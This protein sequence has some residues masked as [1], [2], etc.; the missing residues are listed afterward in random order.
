[1]DKKKN[2]IWF[3]RSIQLMNTFPFSILIGEG[4]P[5]YVLNLIRHGNNEI[6]KQKITHLYSS[7]RPFAD[8]FAAYILKKMNPG[9]FWIADFRDLMFDPYFNKIYF[10]KIHQRFFR[11]IFWT[12][13]LVTTISDGL[14]EKLKP[15]NQNVITLKNGIS[16]FPE[17]FIPAQNSKFSIAY[18]GS[19]YL[20]KKNA[21]PLFVALKQLMEEVKVH[22]ED[23][24]IIYAG[25]DSFYWKE[26][27]DAYQMTAL[28]DDRGALSSEDA[29]KIQQNVCINLLL[30]IS[31]EEQTGILTG[32]MIE[33]FEAGNPVLAIVKN[34]ID[35]ELESNLQEL[36][37]GK[38]FS[39]H[40]SEIPGI[41]EFIYNEYLQWEKSGT[42]R[43]AVDVN[44]LKKKYAVEETMRPLY[45]KIRL[46]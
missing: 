38:S 18:T 9:V 36:H 14:A 25:K 46:I 7:F 20:D 37:I 39:D 12:A 8:H 42:N 23:V 11:N 28:L 43:K 17:S 1:M 27:A 4:G 44:M 31:S 45:E 15:Y 32:K 24:T 22:R 2:S 10:K 29:M 3:Q 21:E 30:S 35:P 6:R 19:M 5:I 16:K 26:M 13:D 33:Y 34:Q 40:E 41:K